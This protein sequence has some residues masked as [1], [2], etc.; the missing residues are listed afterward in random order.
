MCSRLF[1]EM[2]PGRLPKRGLPRDCFRSPGIN[3]LLKRNQ[4]LPSVCFVCRIMWFIW[5]LAQCWISM[6][7]WKVYIWLRNFSSHLGGHRGSVDMVG[8]V[9]LF[10]FCFCFFCLF[11][12]FFFFF[13][14]SF[15]F[16]GGLNK[17]TVNKAYRIMVI[18]L[19]NDLGSLLLT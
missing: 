5:H 13:F 1:T 10:C 17:L 8:F 14:F 9:V 15:F 19:V 12:C 7:L 4:N 3:S 6:A 16:G 11:V 2:G 18:I